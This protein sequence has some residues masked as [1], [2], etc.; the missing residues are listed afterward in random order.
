MQRV[1]TRGGVVCKIRVRQNA[2]FIAART[3]IFGEGIHICIDFRQTK[4]INLRNTIEKQE[5]K[6]FVTHFCYRC[7]SIRAA[8]WRKPQEQQR[9]LVSR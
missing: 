2:L 9:E 8:G 1:H 5:G 4:Y 7:F 6:S 3:C